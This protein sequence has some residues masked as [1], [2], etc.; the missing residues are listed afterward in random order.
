[1]LSAMYSEDN[2][3]ASGTCGAKRSNTSGKAVPSRAGKTN[4]FSGMS[5]CTAG[6]SSQS[7]TSA[8]ASG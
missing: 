2:S 1:M 6:E 3:S 4:M 5:A 7:M 8:A